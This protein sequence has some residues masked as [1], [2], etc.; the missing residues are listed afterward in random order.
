MI[1]GG[2]PS[3]GLYGEPLQSGPLLMHIEPIETRSRAFNW[4]IEV[5]LHQ[6]LHQILWLSSGQMQAQVNGHRRLLA[7]PT[8]IVVPAH[9]VHSFSPAETAQGYVLT[10]RLEFFHCSE[11]KVASE[12][13]KRLCAAPG[14]ISLAGPA[15]AAA[16]V[17]AL[18]GVLMREYQTGHERNDLVMDRLTKAICLLLARHELEAL[19]DRD[20]ADGS[21]ELA[22][23]LT[24][25]DRYFAT[26]LSL[27][28]YAAHLNC[29]EERLIRL[30]RKGTGKT[31]MQLVHE[32]RLREACHRLSHVAAPV[33]EISQDLG[34]SDVAYFCRFFK[35]NIGCTPSQYRAA[36]GSSRAA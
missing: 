3:Y 19:G 31:P 25:V 21:A 16:D 30:V 20:K 28:E 15:H 36:H 1:Q 22:P 8:A 32:R 12:V 35:K 13:F 33:S 18:I 24:L 10:M 17:D 29:H 11:S 14:L 5:H 34:F 9:A 27:A 4:E 23:F 7:G 26:D 6:N 2:V